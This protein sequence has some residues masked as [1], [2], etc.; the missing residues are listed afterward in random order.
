MSNFCRM[1][2]NLY[3]SHSDSPK[4]VYILTQNRKRRHKL[5]FQF[6]PKSNDTIYHIFTK[7]FCNLKFKWW[8]VVTW[9]SSSNHRPAMAWR[10][11]L[12]N[13][14]QRFV[15][16]PRHLHQTVGSLGW[17]LRAI[18]NK[19]VIDGG[20]TDALKTRRNDFKFKTD[21]VLPSADALLERLLLEEMFR[22]QSSVWLA[23][24]PTSH[25]REKQWKNDANNSVFPWHGTTF[26]E[27]FSGDFGD[28]S[29][30]HHFGITN[31]GKTHWQKVLRLHFLQ[32][33][34]LWCYQWFL[35]R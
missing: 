23:G 27:P 7:H 18:E 17:L 28:L 4:N 1:F 8:S 30:R 29:C 15:F 26:Y 22:L 33:L 3:I 2:A 19:S 12:I 31:V 25:W 24:S 10:D 9:F 32:E 35:Q 21:F 34:F 13:E 5:F 14:I 11:W 20:M 16:A 6:R